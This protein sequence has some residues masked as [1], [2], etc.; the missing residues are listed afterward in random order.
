[1]LLFYKHAGGHLGWI[2][3]SDGSGGWRGRP[4]TEDVFLDYLESVLA[5]DAQSNKSGQ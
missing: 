1:M 5:M 2:N 3:L 4:W